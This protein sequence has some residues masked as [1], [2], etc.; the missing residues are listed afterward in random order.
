MT[1]SSSQSTYAPE[2]RS[3]SR[4][5]TPQWFRDAK[6]GVYSHWGLA[7]LKHLPGNENRYLRELI[8]EFTADRFDPEEWADLFAA[9]GAR[10][11]GLTAWHGHGF[12]HW[13]SDVTPWNSVSQGP[14]IDIAAELGRSIRARGMKF[15]ASFHFG[16]WYSFPHWRQP[17]ISSWPTTG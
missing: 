2:W 14:G 7:T 16:Y 9:S 11:A 4:R 13:K 17:T 3:L 6:F 1:A 5:A 12:V 10:Y 8:P 15:L